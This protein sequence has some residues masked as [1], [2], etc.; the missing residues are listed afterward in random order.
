MILTKAYLGEVAGVEIRLIK[1][2]K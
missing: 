2:Y 1:T